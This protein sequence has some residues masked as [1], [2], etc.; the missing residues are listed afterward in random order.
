MCPSAALKK[1]PRNFEQ[2]KTCR[3]SFDSIYQ[4]VKN[5]EAGVHFEK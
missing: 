2:Y 5:R 4:R 3:P 1:F